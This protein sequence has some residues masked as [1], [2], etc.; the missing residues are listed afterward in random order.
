VT[1]VIQ[2]DPGTRTDRRRSQRRKRVAKRVLVVLV[3]LALVGG[4]ATLIAKQ[5]TGNSKKGVGLVAGRQRTVLVAMTLHDD[6][7]N[8]ASA[9]TLF[10]VDPE[11]TNPVVLF[12][13]AGT[14]GPIPGLKDFDLMGQALSVGQPSL[15]QI[16]VD[17]LLGID[18]DRTAVIDDVSLGQFIDGIGGITVDVEER[19]LGPG[20]GGTQTLQVPLG[21][22]HMDGAEA[23]TYLTYTSNDLGEVDSFVRA[24]KVWEGIFSAG[25][26]KITTALRALQPDPLSAD[27]VAAIGALWK[28]FAERSAD[29]RTYEV[30][31]G[32]EIGGGGDNV[33][34]KPDTDQIAQMVKRDFS[35]SIPAGVNVAARPRIDLRNG[36]GSPEIGQRAAAVLVPA[37][38]RIIQ[39]GN[40]V[41]FDFASTRIVVYGDD[42]AS[43]ALARKI[44]NL[45]GVGTIQIG[46]RPE[47]VVDVTVVLGKDFVNRVKRS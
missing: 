1:A 15:Q 26:Q 39:T 40:A 4:A 43:L 11:G 17:N 25:G 44:K 22:H 35:G 13:P 38:L 23:V 12:I 34:Y 7:S 45:L 28:A 10:G 3:I 6:A 16:T 27:D 5:T 8:K 20:P 30:L 18:I 14:L 47:S 29:D 24:Q 32:E 33:G 9:L 31:P 19:L 36:N 42:E 37:G 41:N 2:Q 21:K 46:T